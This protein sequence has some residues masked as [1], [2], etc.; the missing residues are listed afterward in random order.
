MISLRTPRITVKQ[1]GINDIFLGN[2]AG[3]SGNHIY[4]ISFNDF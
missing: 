2:V 1:S 4:Y 3:A